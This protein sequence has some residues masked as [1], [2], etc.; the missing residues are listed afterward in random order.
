MNDLDIKIAYWK[1]RLSKSKGKAY[2]DAKKH[3]D[4]LCL[5]RHRRNNGTYIDSRLPK[6]QIWL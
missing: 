2:T 6:E 1:D 4:K 3:Y 5:E